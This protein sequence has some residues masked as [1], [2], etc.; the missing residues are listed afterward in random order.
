M[1]YNSKDKLKVRML[2]QLGQEC[3]EICGEDRY[4]TLEFHHIDPA[5]KRL[6]GKTGSYWSQ[7]RW[8]ALLEEAT[9]CRVLCAN[10][11]RDLHFRKVRG[12]PRKP[13]K[14]RN[15]ERL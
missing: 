12:L 14:F 7:K 5:N 11:H 3:C 9:L 8:D 6:I 2:N 10:C 13:Y 1:A 4:W 15:E